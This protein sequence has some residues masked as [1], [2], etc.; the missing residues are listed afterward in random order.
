VLLG[1]LVVLLLMMVVSGQSWLSS[2]FADA[3]RMAVGVILSF[4][5]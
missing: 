3:G 1:S 5:V 4:E 2:A